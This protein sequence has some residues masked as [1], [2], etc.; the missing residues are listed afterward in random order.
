MY[1]KLAC[2][3]KPDDE[4]IGSY[5]GGVMGVSY[6]HSYLSRQGTK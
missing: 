4:E 5:G 1:K 6:G 2:P 3:A